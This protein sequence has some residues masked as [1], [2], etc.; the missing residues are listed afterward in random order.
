MCETEK[1]NPHIIVYESLQPTNLGLKTSII[2]SQCPY[3]SC[4]KTTE[5]SANADELQHLS[6]H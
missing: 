6:I 4:I 3:T 5:R 1:S 2:L